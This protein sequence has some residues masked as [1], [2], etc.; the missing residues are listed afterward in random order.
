MSFPSLHTSN[1][2]TLEK[3]AHTIRFLSADAVEKAASGHP[4]MP[5]GMAELASVLW[6]RYLN[7]NPSN[8]DW[9][10]RD[11]FVL[12][13]GHG[14]MLLYSMLHLAGYKVS[15]DD[16]KNFRQWE[17]NTPGHPE[18]FMTEGV[19][20]T[21]GPLGQGI[22]NAV[23]MALGQKILSARYATQEFDP[24]DHKVWCFCG[25]GCLM[26]G[27]SSEVSSLAGHLALDNLIIVYDDNNI[28]I[29]GRTDLAFTED[30]EQRYQAYGFHTLRVDGHDIEAIDK[31]Y[32]EA[33]SLKG[34]PVM[35]LAK[36][37]IGKG[38]PNKADSYNVHG[39]PL[40][41]DELTASKKALGWPVEPMFHVPDE[42]R[43]VFAAR[44][45]VLKETFVEWNRSYESWKAANPS[46]Q[47]R[48]DN[49]LQRKLP[50]DL[51]KAL[52]ASLPKGGGAVATRKLSEAVLQA[53]S[54]HVE[55]LIG[56]S[57]DLEPSTLTLIKD[58]S[59][60]LAGTY[61]GKNLRFGVREHGMGSIMNGLAYYGSF[62]PYGSTFF[63][64]LDYM[65]P[66]V[67]LAALCHLQTL[68]IYTHDSIFL[69]EDGPTHQPIEHLQ[70]LRAMPNIQ[71]LRPA[72]G[73][74]TAI[75]YAMA[76][77]K[78]DGPSALILTRQNLP[79]LERPS[80]FTTQDI[81][82][83]AYTVYETAEGTPELVFIATGSEVSL[84]LEVAKDLSSSKSVRVVSMPS[85]EVFKSQSDSYR[86]AL[87][88]ESAKKVT[89]EAGSTFGWKDMV[90]G[91]SKDT[92][93]IGMESFGAS[94]PAGVLAEK[95]GLTKEGVL[96]RLNT[97]W[98][99]H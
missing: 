71:V 88:P 95:F 68:Y 59:D 11:R 81:R 48:L 64:F 63:C 43:A 26:E 70:M 80:G 45:E 18:S 8:P 49:Q 62:L 24:V 7:Y 54:S 86:A 30:V 91:T 79:Q 22:G 66:T 33:L 82:K 67:R 60:V 36:T 15:L 90:G 28:S 9:L 29:A 87:I 31:V 20:T 61:A 51:E 41:N 16:I 14:S 5:M 76:L 84:A 6:L 40:G 56:G 94:A 69:G 35:I 12:S 77:E 21:T 50:E 23:G 13:N 1:I 83:G 19:E 98:Q 58:S 75:C 25:D 93:S 52:I 53:A 89:I 44:A 38:S 72:D 34:K 37:I 74:E 57:A 3:A 2:A 32:Q 97:F 73:L 96:K 47:E 55:A 99:E 10:G 92:L 17:S 4:G 46:L 85:Y 39:S 42:V 27:V 78:K 65:K